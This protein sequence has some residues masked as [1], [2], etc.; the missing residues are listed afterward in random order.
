[1]LPDSSV[2]THCIFA[3]LVFAKVIAPDGILSATPSPTESNVN[4]PPNKSPPLA[5]QPLALLRI[6]STGLT[7]RL[8]QAPS[9]SSMFNP[10]ARPVTSP[11][12]AKLQ[13]RHVPGPGS[14]K[15]TALGIGGKPKI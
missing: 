15:F 6:T 14:S 10:G 3:P 2:T 4:G 7:E 12:N 1:M 9:I 8:K 13:I 11:S 5:L